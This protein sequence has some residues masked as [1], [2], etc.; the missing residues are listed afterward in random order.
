MSVCQPL[1][2]AFVWC[3]SM[4]KGRRAREQEEAELIFV[5]RHSLDDDI[6]PLVSAEP[7]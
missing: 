7:S 1:A 5:T 6:N 3:H 2:R 4:V